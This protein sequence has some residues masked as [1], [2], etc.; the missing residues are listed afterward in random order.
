M[1]NRRDRNPSA[2]RL[3]SFGWRGMEKTQRKDGEPR[4][5]R[6]WLVAGNGAGDRIRTGDIDLGKVALYQLSYSRFGGV[7]GPI[8]AP[9]AT[10]CQIRFTVTKIAGMRLKRC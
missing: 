2:G 5:I 3:G 7:T 9:L 1:V 8:V 4:G 10:R 6:V